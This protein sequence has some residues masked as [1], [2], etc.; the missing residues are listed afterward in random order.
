[1]GPRSPQ[2]EYAVSRQELNALVDSY[3]SKNTEFLDK[4]SSAQPVDYQ[5]YMLGVISCVRLLCERMMFVEPFDVTEAV[6]NLRRAC[7]TTNSPEEFV[8][9]IPIEVSMIEC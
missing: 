1:M 5:R 8:S 2:L 4:L 9:T 3:L 7:K 6:F